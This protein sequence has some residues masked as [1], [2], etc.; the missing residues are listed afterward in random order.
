MSDLG[1]AIA[2]HIGRELV[3]AGIAIGAGLVLVLIGLGWLGYWLWTH[4][5]W[6]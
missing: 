2:E 3:H 4:L 1:R 5:Q 6:V